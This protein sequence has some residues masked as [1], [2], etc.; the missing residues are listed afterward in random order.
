[1]TKTMTTCGICKLTP[2]RAGNCP[3]CRVRKCRGAGI[4]GERCSVPGCAVD[5][6]RVLRW[7]RFT[8]RTVALCANHE[9]LAGRR[10]LS[11]STYLDVVPPAEGWAQSA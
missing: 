1:M 2:V 6:P 11:W 4:D 3:A 8:D 5:H 9:A 10:P 7:H